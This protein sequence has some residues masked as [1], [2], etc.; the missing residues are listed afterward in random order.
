MPTDLKL[1]KGSTLRLPCRAR[2]SPPPEVSVRGSSIVQQ[3]SLLECPL[4]RGQKK[5]L[6]SSEV[7]D[8]VSS[9]SEVIIRVYTLYR[10]VLVAPLPPKVCARCSSSTEVSMRGSPPPELNMRGYPPSEISIR[11]FLSLGVS[12]KDSIQRLPSLRGQGYLNAFS[13]LQ[14][15]V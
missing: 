15:S 4:F 5:R 1:L 11:C 14:R 8:G 12:M 3:R 9:P 13:L 7:G 2:G 6:A 10:L